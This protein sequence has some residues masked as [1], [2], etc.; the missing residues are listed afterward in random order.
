[1]VADREQTGIDPTIYVDLTVQSDNETDDESYRNRFLFWDEIDDR[2]GEI[3]QNVPKKK[4]YDAGLIVK[5]I[6]IKNNF[7]TVKGIW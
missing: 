2:N 3:R 6:D 5:L 4:R 7:G 1:M